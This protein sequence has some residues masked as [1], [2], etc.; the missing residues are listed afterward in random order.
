[1][2]AADAETSVQTALL[3]APMYHELSLGAELAWHLP[4]EDHINYGYI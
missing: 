1:M 2:S 4:A 3:W